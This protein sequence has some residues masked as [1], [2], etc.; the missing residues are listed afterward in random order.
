MDSAYALLR[1]LEIAA[2]MKRGWVIA[3]VV[4]ALLLALTLLATW[5]DVT[6][7]VP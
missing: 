6:N 4:L 2:S 1:P 3:L 7:P 5:Q